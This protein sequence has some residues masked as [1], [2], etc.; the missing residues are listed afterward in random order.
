MER[1]FALILTAAALSLI[2]CVKNP[3]GPKQEPQNPPGTGCAKGPY[4]ST[5]V[6]TAEY[7]PVCGCD[8]VTYGNA[9]EAMRNGVPSWTP[10]E[11]TP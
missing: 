9:C 11:C 1:S 5:L 3:M 7:E 4:D 8:N 10:G 6:C 2:A